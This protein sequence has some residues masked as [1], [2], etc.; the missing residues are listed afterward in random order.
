MSTSLRADSFQIVG[1]Q[2]AATLQDAHAALESYAEG[3]AG[4]QGLLLCADHLHAA[5]GALQLTE[6]YG[7]SLLAEE[8]GAACGT[9]EGA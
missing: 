8:V 7:A 3:D 1:E 4:T 9:A 6:V 2:V 5:R